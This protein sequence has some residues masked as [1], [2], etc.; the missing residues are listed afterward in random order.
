MDAWAKPAGNLSAAGCARGL[1]FGVLA[2]GVAL[3]LA[4]ALA[5]FG[6]PWFWRGLLILPFYVASDGL[7]KGLYR[8]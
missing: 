2:L 5:A 6:V 8:T 7:S 3:V 1:R 4:V